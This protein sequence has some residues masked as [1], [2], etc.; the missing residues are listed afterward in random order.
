MATWFEDPE[1]I[2]LQT[3]SL[4]FNLLWLSETNW[5]AKTSED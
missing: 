4:R 5:S 3:E 2:Q 1:C